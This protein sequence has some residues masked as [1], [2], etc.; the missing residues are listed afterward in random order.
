MEPDFRFRLA[1]VGRRE[2]KVN[3][4]SSPPSRACCIGN[5]SG[6]GG[7]GGPVQHRGRVARKERWSKR[8]GPLTRVGSR[9][10]SH[11]GLGR[12]SG[13]S[14]AVSAQWPPPFCLLSS[15]RIWAIGK[16]K[17]DRKGGGGATCN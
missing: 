7:E 9:V 2:L 15:A 3:R 12:A 11:A 10:P 1:E 6:G 8:G 14:P 17:R 13:W 4:A 16:P 5:S